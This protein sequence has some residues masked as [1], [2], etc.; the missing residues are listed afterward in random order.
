VKKTVLV[1]I[2]LEI[3]PPRHLGWY[4]DMERR[5]RACENWAAEFMEFV[6]DHRSQ[7]PVSIHVIRDEQE[8]CSHCGSEW[9]EDEAGPL[10]CAKAM[11]EHSAA[12]ASA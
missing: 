6:R 12:K 8:Q 2:R 9:E 4:P 1:D 11:D 10:C 5:A 3:E 7:D